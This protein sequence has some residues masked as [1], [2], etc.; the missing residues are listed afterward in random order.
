MTVWDQPR[1]AAQFRAQVADPLATRQRQGY[2]TA[3]VPETVAGKAAVRIVIAPTGW[4]G[5][6]SLPAAEIDEK[7]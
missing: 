4:S 5:W 7:R 3:V 1:Y 2:R 6:K